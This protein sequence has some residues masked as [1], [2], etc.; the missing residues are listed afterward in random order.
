MATMLLMFGAVNA[1]I[2]DIEVR[3]QW[4]YVYGE[5]NKQLCST[6]IS[7]DASLKGYCS[8]FYV[9][10]EGQWLYTKD[11]NCETINSMT[12]SSDAIVRG[13]AGK[14]FTIKE[15]QWIYTYDKNCNQLSSRTGN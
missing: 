3:G 7:S 11:S 2:A 14:S 12:I 8:S 1:Q 6:T 4:I 5:N 13:V 15:G 10:R 9:I